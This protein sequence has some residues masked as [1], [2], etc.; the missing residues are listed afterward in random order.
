MQLPAPEAVP[1]LLPALDLTGIFVFGLSG[2]LLAVRRHLDLFG[3]VV[4]ALTAG[5]GGGIVRDLLL[6]D[7]PPVALRDIRYLVAGMTAGLV[8]FVA[9]HQLERIGRAVRVF[10]AAG[11]GLFAVAGAAKAVA[12]S[13]NALTAILIGVLTGTGG[14]ALRDVLANEV[15][16]VL[17]R[18]IYAVAALAG[19]VVVVVGDLVGAPP[20]PVAIGGAVGT[21]VLRMVALR[22]GWHA[23]RATGPAD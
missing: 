13:M 3:A 18:E 11:L 23:P 4:L 16:L 9:H 14:G 21:F 2:G 7:V 12:F 20:A 1:W 10:D 15:P 8:A 5:L 17:R 6:G 22:L 19:A